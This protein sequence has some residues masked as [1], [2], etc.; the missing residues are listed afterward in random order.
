MRC[1]GCGAVVPATEGPTHRYMTSAPAC[2]ATYGELTAVLLS[3]PAATSYRQW[4]VD[5]F[6]VQHPGEP[7]E[8]AIQSVAA[9]LL[10]L[11]ATLE[12]NAPGAGSHRVIN[13]VTARKGAY[14]WLTPPIAF[15][16]TVGDVLA[17]RDQLHDAAHKWARSAW[18][19]WRPHHDQVK[20]WHSA[21]FVS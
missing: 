3:D 12:L 5:A 13:A 7:T 8:Q 9:H 16:V 10:S 11:Y 2:W 21:L 20:A 15:T 1:V 19:A 4:C 18:D 17:S 6:A 14:A